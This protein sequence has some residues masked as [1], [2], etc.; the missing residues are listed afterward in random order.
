MLHTMLLPFSTDARQLCKSCIL[1]YTYPSL[2]STEKCFS[3]VG[4]DKY[5]PRAHLPMMMG[6]L[7]VGVDRQN[8]YRFSVSRNLG[9]EER[10]SPPFGHQSK[11]RLDEKPRTVTAGFLV[12]AQFAISCCASHQDLSLRT[13]YRYHY[14]SNTGDLVQTHGRSLLHHQ[15]QLSCAAVRTEFC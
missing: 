15:Q 13:R 1:K 4:I 9:M 2:N 12:G 11:I 6:V 14:S 3:C 10:I 5:D 8:D 7:F